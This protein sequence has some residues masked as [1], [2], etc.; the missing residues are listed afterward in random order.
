M[1]DNEISKR[2]E[3]NQVAG[4]VVRLEESIDRQ[5]QKLDKL[6]VYVREILRR[7]GR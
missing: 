7:M 3:V 1:D 5:E 2:L 6:Q 4:I